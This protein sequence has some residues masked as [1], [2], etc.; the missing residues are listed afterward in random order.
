VVSDDPVVHH[1]PHDIQH[2][3]VKEECRSEAWR[4]EGHGEKVAMRAAVRVVAV[5]FEISKQ[6]RPKRVSASIDQ[7]RRKMSF[8]Y[9]IALVSDLAYLVLN[10]YQLAIP[11]GSTSLAKL[12]FSNNNVPR[13]SKNEVAHRGTKQ[14]NYKMVGNL[15]LGLFQG[16]PCD[17]VAV[18]VLKP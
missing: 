1:A 16:C 5:D 4:L 7:G 9:A 2:L 17:D 12:A 10:R 3:I 11:R 14:L 8:E 13:G 6:K 15:T 18:G